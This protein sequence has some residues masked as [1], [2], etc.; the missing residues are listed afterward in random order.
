MPLPP[1]PAA[2]TSKVTGTVV[3]RD[4]TSI[5]VEGKQKGAETY[6]IDSKTKF[7]GDVRP[8]SEVTVKWED[9]AGMQRATAVEAKKT[10]AKH[11]S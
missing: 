8:G 1:A 6:M 7:K 3:S 9:H 2:Q 5:K 11:S 4:E 10:K